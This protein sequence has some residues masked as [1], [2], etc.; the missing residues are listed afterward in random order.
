MCGY[1]NVIIA[2]VI[3]QKLGMMQKINRRKFLKLGLLGG[4][5]TLIASYPFF[6]ERY[7]FQLNTYRIPVSDLPSNFNGFTIAQLT[8]IHYGFLMPLMVIE[9]IVD[10]INMLQSDIIVCT[11]DYIHE[12]NGITQID[13][14]WT[15]LMKLSAKYGVYSVSGNHDHWGDT[16]R[17]LYWL[18][19]SGQNVRHKAIPILK[20]EERIWIGGAGDYW[21]DKLGID[22]AFQ[23]VP[24]SE[25]KILLSHNP[26]SAD[27]KY[28]TQVNLIISGHT[29]GG[30]VNIPFVGSPILPV[31]NKS[32]SSGFIKT[33]RT[34]LYI[35]KGL[36]WAILPVRFNCFPE[37][38]VLKLVQEMT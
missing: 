5:G 4:I 38:S 29:H 3:C 24:S 18:E 35:S 23:H 12:Q 33:G 15:R 6:I 8:D 19:K 36:G 27:T 26:D 1:D 22:N 10:R 14:V 30:Q 21:E 34:S 9:Q 20:G 7:I 31:R 11:G 32:Y 16:N 2:E 37:I 28:E 17:S 25:C 13:I